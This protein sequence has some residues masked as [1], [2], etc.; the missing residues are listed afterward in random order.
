MESISCHITPLV[1]N[2]FRGRH[3]NTHMQTHTHTDVHT[4]KI[5]RNQVHAGHRP[6]PPGLKNKQTG[7]RS[8]SMEATLDE[9]QGLQENEMHLQ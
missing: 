6:A 1:I 7:Y 2:N 5:L 4:E 8:K 3:A 9:A